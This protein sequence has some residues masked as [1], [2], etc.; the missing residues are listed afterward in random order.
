M[1]CKN[2]LV[3]QLLI[4]AGVSLATGN[5]ASAAIVSAMVI[6]LDLPEKQD[7]G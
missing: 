5:P 4:I 6:I 3:I 1:R 2:P 7:F